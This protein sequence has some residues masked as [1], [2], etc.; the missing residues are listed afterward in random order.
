MPPSTFCAPQLQSMCRYIVYHYVKIWHVR[1]GDA[2]NMQP[3]SW[4]GGAQT[5]KIRKFKKENVPLISSI[6][7]YSPLSQL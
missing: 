7:R 4:G 5:E 6:S 2:N 1:L 3:L